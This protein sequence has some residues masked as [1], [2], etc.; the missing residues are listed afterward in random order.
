M[1]I[2][3][4]ASRIA[5]QT[6]RVINI[7][8]DVAADLHFQELITER[9]SDHIISRLA[10]SIFNCLLKLIKQPANCN[11]LTRSR[12]HF[13][14]CQFDQASRVIEQ[15]SLQGWNRQFAS[16]NHA[17]EVCRLLFA[18]HRNR[19]VQIRIILILQLN[20]SHIMR[21]IKT[22]AMRSNKHIVERAVFTALKDVCA[23]R[24]GEHLWSFLFNQ[25]F[26]QFFSFAL[27]IT[28]L[29]RHVS[30]SPNI[31]VNFV[32]TPTFTDFVN[33]FI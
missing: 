30:K 2:L 14:S 16:R 13:P 21:A 22:I 17:T 25:R 10:A 28:S 9:A 1:S 11:N 7:K 5:S 24:F 27:N 6:Y 33:L 15:F 29:N 8:Y 20:Q 3:Q 19:Q 23:V 4:V 12:T 31:R 18:V 32:K 26:S